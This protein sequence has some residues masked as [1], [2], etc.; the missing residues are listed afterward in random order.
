MAATNTFSLSIPKPCHEKWSDF[1]P[2]DGGGYCTSCSKV[3]IDFTTMTDEEILNFIKNKPT[4]A[5]GRFRSRQ[6]GTYQLTTASCVKPGLKLLRAGIVSLLL[7]LIGKPTSAQVAAISP[8]QVEMRAHDYVLGK[9][10]YHDSEERTTITGIVRDGD[11]DMAAPG[12]NVLVKGSTRGTTTDIDGRFQIS[13]EEG[14]VLVFSF[15]G[16]D[17]QE[18]KVPQNFN[19]M[20]ELVITLTSSITMGELA[21]NGIYTEPESAAKKLWN[22]VK[23][24]F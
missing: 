20:P 7:V 9:V 10:A 15:I 12:V 4:H 3:V 17:T 11:M 19:R 14:D 24:L 16:Y 22:K 5:C 13:V 2:S 23:S 6:L 18:Y 8:S 21:I 1:I